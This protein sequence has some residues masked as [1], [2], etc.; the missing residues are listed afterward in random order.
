MDTEQLA[1]V[2]TGT[3]MRLAATDA[4]FASAQTGTAQTRGTLTVR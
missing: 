4:S 1:F 2:Q 3:G